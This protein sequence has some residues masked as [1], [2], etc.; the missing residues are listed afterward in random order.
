M[1]LI[2]RAQAG[3]FDAILSRPDVERL[4]CTTGLRTPAFRLVKDG[5]Q[6]PLR[7]YTEDI[8]WHPGAFSGTAVVERVAAEFAQGATLVLQALHIHWLAAARYCRGLEMALECPVQANAYFTPARAQGFAI[9]HDTHDVFILQVAGSK[10]WRVWRP[11][12]ELPRPLG[13]AAKRLARL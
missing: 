3:R 8:T 6:L 13:A 5:A 12:L 2:R 11:V 9:H 7:D 4:V 1:L 10:R